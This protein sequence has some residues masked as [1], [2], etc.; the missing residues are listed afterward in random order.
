MILAILIG[1]AQ[2]LG[3]GASAIAAHYTIVEL[4]VPSGFIGCY[5][6]VVNDSGQAAGECYNSAGN[7]Y[8]ATEWTSGVARVLFV[9]HSMANRWT[10]ASGLNASGDVV[11]Y[12]QPPGAFQALRWHLGSLELL[13]ALPGT[14]GT[15]ASAI[16]DDGTIIGASG[17][18]SAEWAT[19]TVIDLGGFQ[20]SAASINAHGEFVGFGQISRKDPQGG[21]WLDLGK[22]GAMRYIL[23][24][25]FHTRAWSVNDDGVVV[26]V[27]ESEI[28]HEAWVY[29][30]GTLTYL[31]SLGPVGFDQ[32]SSVNDQGIIVGYSLASAVRWYN[33]SVSD[34]NSLIP[35]ASGVRLEEAD[36]ISP[37]GLI[38]CDATTSS[39]GIGV[40]LYPE[41]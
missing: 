37:H 14:T 8:R 9:P 26:G 15:S 33:G 25:D 30:D 41:R 18:H 19:G 32:A 34:L 39:G 7:L 21:A 24:G 12:A 28:G 4:P 3:T 5:A 27:T 22:P 20:T 11:G 31:P 13:P 35:P 17:G 10:W 1:I 6:T 16:R 23:N 36:S 29:R 38:A 40:I 2:I